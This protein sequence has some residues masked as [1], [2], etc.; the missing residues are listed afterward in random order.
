[1]GSDGAILTARATDVCGTYSGEYVY[2]T[3]ERDF[4]SP[5]THAD[6]TFG[7]K[8]DDAIYAAGT[9]YPGYS[10]VDEI[11][12]GNVCNTVIVDSTDIMASGCEVAEFDQTVYPTSEA[13]YR[14]RRPVSTAS[15]AA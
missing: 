9:F 8:G 5:R 3:S 1:M 6:S 15:S 14:S 11:S 4:I 13:L 2:G 10:S 12:C 7:Y